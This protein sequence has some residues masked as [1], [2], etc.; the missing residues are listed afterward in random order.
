MRSL[1]SWFSLVITCVLGLVYFY[2]GSRLLHA[3]GEWALFAL[4][5]AL[6][7][8]LLA[9]FWS[10]DLE[11]KSERGRLGIRAFQWSSFMSMAGL[12][13]VLTLTVARDVLLG[14]ALQLGATGLA[15]FF[16]ERADRSLLLLA[17]VM[18]GA[19]LVRGLG[20]PRIRRVRVA[21]AG[22]DPALEGFT[23][24]QVSDLHVGPVIRRAYARRVVDRVNALAP[25][26]I[27]LT[28]DIADA[29]VSEIRDEIAPLAGLRARHGVFFALGNHEY[30]WGAAEWTAE[31]RRLGARALL[32]SSEVILHG[33]A[34]MRVAGVVDYAA[35]QHDELKT[36]PDPAAAI[37]GERAA[38]NLLLA[39]Q[40]K[41]AAE[42]ERAGFDLQLSGHTHNGQFFPWTWVV[43]R[44][45]RIYVGLHPLG[46]L[47]VYVSPGTGSWGPPVRLGSTTEIT[48]LTLNLAAR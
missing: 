2:L 8:S 47:W 23:I 21:I 32:N 48:F 7:W 41:I 28:G 44:V 43:R 1:L 19:G 34:R 46:R 37:A 40:P 13:F 15:P 42:A 10:L 5:F 25:D 11:V 17:L 4:P 27:A 24:A 6:I 20:G 29:A 30:Y 35:L 45:H 38:F 3:R 12:S 39:H 36:G 31:L 33:G 9:V 22:L 26:L 16:T 18:L 14:T